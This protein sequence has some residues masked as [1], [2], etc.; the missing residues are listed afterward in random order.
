MPRKISIMEWGF[1]C[2]QI[3]LGP[4]RRIWCV[5]SFALTATGLHIISHLSRWGYSAR[6]MFVSDS[7]RGLYNITGG[8]A[9]G[10][11]EATF[12]FEVLVKY[13]RSRCGDETLVNRII[14]CLQYLPG[15]WTA[16][17][18]LPGCWTAV[19]Y[20]PGFWT[21]VQYP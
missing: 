4:T 14:L 9:T 16:V 19:Q 5:W 11:A 13:L 12:F 20:L 2:G 1:T 6:V 3:A 8:S 18:Y 17:Q 15:F 7:K 10:V 21:A